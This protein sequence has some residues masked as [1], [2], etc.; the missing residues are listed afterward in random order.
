M[1]RQSKQNIICNKTIRNPSENSFLLTLM[2]PFNIYQAE[3]QF[4]HVCSLSVGNL[5]AR[6]KFLSACR[7]QH[8]ALC[9]TSAQQ[10]RSLRD[11]GKR[12]MA[13]KWA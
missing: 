12:E 9:Y 6:T 10:I 1:L 7:V 11:G 5:R 3:R 2:L 8:A 13:E 4:S